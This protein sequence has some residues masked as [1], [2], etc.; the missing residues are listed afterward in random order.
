M[1]QNV[2]R[3]DEHVQGHADHCHGLAIALIG[4]ISQEDSEV[5]RSAWSAKGLSFLNGFIRELLPILAARYEN[6]LCPCPLLHL[7]PL[8]R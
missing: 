4:K 5:K 8:E 2:P 1:R 3:A 6:L 7:S